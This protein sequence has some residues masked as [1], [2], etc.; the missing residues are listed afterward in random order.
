MPPIAQSYFK[1]MSLVMEELYRVCKDDARLA[2][3]IGGGCFPEGVIDVDTTL[4]NISQEIG[5]KID[6]ILVARENW[7]TKKRTIKVGKMRES[8]VILKKS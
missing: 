8:V 1:D 4:A 7:C 5:F 6:R 3:V 2:I